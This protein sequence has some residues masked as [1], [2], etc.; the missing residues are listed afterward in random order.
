VVGS[1]CSGATWTA[2]IDQRGLLADEQMAST[3]KHQ[4]TLLLRRFGGHEPHVGPGDRL[5]NRF[6]VCHV[7]LLPF[8]VGLNVSRRHQSYGMAKRLQLARPMMRRGASLDANQA[9]RQLLEERQHVAMT[10]WPP[11]STPWTWKTDSAMSKPIVVTVCMAR[12][13]ELWEP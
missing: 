11:A 2:R 4:A 8:D 10:T 1:D 7:I 5:T 9:W 13:S 12:S 3:M 6:C